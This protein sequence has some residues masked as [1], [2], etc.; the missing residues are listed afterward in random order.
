MGKEDP[1]QVAIERANEKRRCA[2]EKRPSKAE[3]RPAKRQ[4]PRAAGNRVK[5]CASPDC[6]LSGTLGEEHLGQKYCCKKCRTSIGKRKKKHNTGK[7]GCKATAS[8]RR[9]SE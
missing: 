9:L 2:A 3:K 4:E 6:T 7:R 8:R 1:K 5:I